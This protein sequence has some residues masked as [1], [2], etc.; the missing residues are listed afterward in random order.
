MF[1]LGAI[2]KRTQL[3]ELAELAKARDAAIGTPDMG[4]A[5]EGI[6]SAF[7]T[8]KMKAQFGGGAQSV[9]TKQLN[10][11]T[12]QLS[13]LNKIVTSTGM[14]ASTTGKNSIGMSITDAM[15]KFGKRAFGDMQKQEELLQEG[16]E[17]N[18]SGFKSV[19]DAIIELGKRGAQA[20]LT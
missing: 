20:V 2:D 19:T 13:S 9:A 7:G 15:E 1:E 11:A 3:L 17:I 5:V 4:Q 18:N 10:T 8:V 16:N 14:M 12:Q 6:Q